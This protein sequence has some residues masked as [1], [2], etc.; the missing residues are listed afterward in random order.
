MRSTV[1]L[2]GLMALAAGAS[3]ASAQDVLASFSYDSL[4][5]SYVASTATTGTFSA[6]AANTQ[7]LTTGGFFQRIVPAVGTA[8][9]PNG[10]VSDLNA[11]DIFTSMSITKTSAS[12]ADG[13]GS[14]TIVDVDGD[15]FTATING[16]NNP[17]TPQTEGWSEIAPVFSGSL[18]NISFTSN[19]GLFNGYTGSFGVPLPA[20]FLEGAIVNLVVGGGTNFF[21][22]SYANRAV[23]ISGQIIPTPGALALMGLGGLAAARRRR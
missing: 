21:N 19:D 18:S 22:T 1:V 7:S 5:G 20:D 8:D 12:T 15:V 11:A 14:I 3:S 4:S 13:F 2:A 17:G 16:V 9:F 6:A 10:F 23:G